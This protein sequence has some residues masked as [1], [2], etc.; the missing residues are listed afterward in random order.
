MTSARTTLIASLIAS[1]AGIGAWLFGVG[2][3][4]W[5]AHPQLAVFFLTLVCTIVLMIAWPQKPA[6]YSKSSSQGH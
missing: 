3:F 6:D 1:A 4:I 5:P 2:N